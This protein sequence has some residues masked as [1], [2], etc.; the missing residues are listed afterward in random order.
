MAELNCEP[1][2]HDHKAFLQKAS[3]PRYSS[4]PTPRTARTI[5]AASASQ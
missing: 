2:L 5:N 4:L 1:V 3:A